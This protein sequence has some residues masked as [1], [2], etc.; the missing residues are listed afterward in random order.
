MT[1]FILGTQFNADTNNLTEPVKAQ[2]VETGT[3]EEQ[4]IE[5]FGVIRA[6][7]KGEWTVLD[8]NGHTPQNIS[9][10]EQTNNNI[11]VYYKVPMKDVHW[12]SITPDE[13]L[14]VNNINTGASVGLDK[15][16]IYLAQNG[17]KID[18][19]IVTRPGANVWVYIVGEK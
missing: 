4:K 1:A 14:V 3:G 5:I 11:I 12:S 9:Y 18:P 8:D 13:T 17:N 19:K 10:I 2:V 15:A 7:T 16:T 6:G